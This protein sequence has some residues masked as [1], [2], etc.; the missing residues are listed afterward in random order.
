MRTTAI[1]LYVMLVVVCILSISPYILLH[2]ASD[3][4]IVTVEEELD[5]LSQGARGWEYRIGRDTTVGAARYTSNGAYDTLICRSFEVQKLLFSSYYLYQFKRVFE[6]HLHQ[7]HKVLHGDSLN[8]ELVVYDRDDTSSIPSVYLPYIGETAREQYNKQICGLQSPEHTSKIISIG[9]VLNSFAP[10]YLYLVQMSCGSNAIFDVKSQSEPNVKRF[11]AIISTQIIPNDLKRCTVLCALNEKCVAYNYE[12]NKH[13]TTM[14]SIYF[15]SKVKFSQSGI[16]I[17]SLRET[18][19]NYRTIK[20]RGMVV[21]ADRF[22][23]EIQ[24][25]RISTTPSQASRNIYILLHWMS[26]RA[27]QK[28]INSFAAS[29]SHLSFSKIARSSL[30]KVVICTSK[31]G[32]MT[33]RFPHDKDDLVDVFEI[34]D[35]DLEPSIQSCIYS[36]KKPGSALTGQT[37]KRKRSVVGMTHATDFLLVMEAE[38]LL[39]PPSIIEF[40]NTYTIHG[41]SFFTSRRNTYATANS[42]SMLPSLSV[43]V[44]DYEAC[45]SSSAHA[46]KMPSVDELYFALSLCRL[47]PI[48]IFVPGLIAKSS[49]TI[50]LDR[51]KKNQELI[52]YCNETALLGGV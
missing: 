25:D 43:S 37:R 50:V 32:I 3:L 26:K 49:S 10:G 47:Q 14:S 19:V 46:K 17:E 44:G 16:M 28:F 18:Y 22:N 11:G 4:T 51:E 38:N 29:V 7:K 12:N 24:V 8:Y 5:K 52:S 48:S 20:T 42:Y 1:A 36:H 31:L 15:M 2:F 39:F 40:I 6:R 45:L 30:K 9:I 21:L 35:T 34:E 13:C 41:Y 27:V 23:Q 33:N